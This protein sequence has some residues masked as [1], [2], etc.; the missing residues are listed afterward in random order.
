VRIVAALAWFDEPP[1][2]LARCVRSLQGLVDE[3]VAVDGG[4]R[5]FPGARFASSPPEVRAIRDAAKDAGIKSRVIVPESVFDSQVHKRAFLM[6]EAARDSDWVFVIDAD[7][8][9]SDVDCEA[10][11]EALSS[12]TA[13]VAAVT[14]RNLHQGDELPADYHPDG[15]LRRRFYR[16][17]TTVVVVHSGYSYHGK[18]LLPGEPAVDL[19]EYVTVDHDICNRGTDRNQRAAEYREARTRER[20]EVWV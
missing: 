16:S 20:V 13:L 2:F 6:Q 17:G 7:E 18:H 14:I 1:E 12:T 9:V 19:G 5:W 3:V 15:G 8:W 4:W 10:V 11:R